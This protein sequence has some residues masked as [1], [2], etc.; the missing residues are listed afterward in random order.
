MASKRKKRPSP[1]RG[2]RRASVSKAKFRP[3]IAPKEIARPSIAGRVASKVDLARSH[4]EVVSY[5]RGERLRDTQ[6]GEWVSRQAAKAR[7]QRREAAARA[8]E[9]AE[10]K[11]AARRAR[12]RAKA[13]PAKPSPAP[14]LPRPA[15]VRPPTKAQLAEALSKAQAL[16]RV[17]A[18][19]VAFLRE[20]DVPAPREAVTKFSKK[21]GKEARTK[22]LRDLATN[23]EFLDKMAPGG[24]WDQPAKFF[25]TKHRGT[26]YSIGLAY[27]HTKF[28]AGKANKEKYGY[29][30]KKTG[31]WTSIAKTE[32]GDRIIIHDEAGLERMRIWIKNRMIRH[33]KQAALKNVKLK[34]YNLVW[35]P[36]GPPDTN[37]G[38]S[39]RTF[40]AT[41]DALLSFTGASGD[42][43]S[44][45]E[46]VKA[47]MN[48][49]TSNHEQHPN[50]P[51]VIEGFNI[52]A[53]SD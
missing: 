20:E 29:R 39:R 48:Q 40:T 27:R 10:A 26:R 9:A 25:L 46:A 32:V 42:V 5:A 44:I 24:G 30:D 8:I 21:A 12:A 16:I 31:Q 18:G 14:S 38:Y 22:F 19:E 50:E 43:D 35:F 3:E 33:K 23:K 1:I 45:D 51:F 41:P 49:I 36:V 11:E 37:F 2:K 52:H 47:F 15:R 53:Y 4:V 28:S 17:Q 13:K 7:L 6:T 34:H